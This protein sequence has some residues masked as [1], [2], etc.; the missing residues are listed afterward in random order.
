MRLLHGSE[1]QVCPPDGTASLAWVAGTRATLRWIHGAGHDPT[2]PD[3]MDVM[4]AALDHFARTGRF[5]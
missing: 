5:L 3:M 1:D 2:H 4:R